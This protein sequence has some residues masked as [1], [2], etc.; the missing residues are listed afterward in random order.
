MVMLAKDGLRR[1]WLVPSWPVELAAE[2]A[3]VAAEEELASA[4]GVAAA[5]RPRR[6]PLAA[7]MGRLR[8]GDCAGLLIRIVS[9]LRAALVES[10]SGGYL[11]WPLHEK[12]R[13]SISKRRNWVWTEVT[14]GRHGVREGR[15]N[16]PWHSLKTFE[17]GPF[18][19]PSGAKG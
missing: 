17:P 11:S 3:A 13:W 19:R 12:S 8:L 1:R 4:G 7:S 9:R 10:A 14:L 18:S 6:A 2:A 5:K 15:H 16:L